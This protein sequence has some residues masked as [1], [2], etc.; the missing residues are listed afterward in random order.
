VPSPGAHRQLVLSESSTT[1]K[2][3]LPHGNSVSYRSFDRRWIFHTRPL[4]RSGATVEGGSPLSLSDFLDRP[5]ALAGAASA[6][7]GTPGVS[8]FAGTWSC[9]VDSSQFAFTI[10]RSSYLGC[11]V[12]IASIILPLERKTTNIAG[13]IS[14]LRNMRGS[15]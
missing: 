4:I 7:S 3:F 10:V 1:S 11:D 12:V 5:V 14:E 9:A 15:K 8:A 6:P 13:Q 2:S